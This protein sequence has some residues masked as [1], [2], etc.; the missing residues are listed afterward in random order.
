MNTLDVEKQNNHHIFL[1]SKKDSLFL[2][3]GEERGMFSSPL[4]NGK[5]VVRRKTTIEIS[6]FV[7]DEINESRFTHGVGFIV[8][9][10][11]NQVLIRRADAY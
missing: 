9:L 2:F 5:R 6:I 7:I 1:S 11:I 10:W 3:K 8:N 4:P